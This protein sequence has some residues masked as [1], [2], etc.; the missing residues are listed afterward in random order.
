MKKHPLLVKTPKVI[1]LE[2]IENQVDYSDT[3]P[4][5][6]RIIEATRC[7]ETGA[8]IET[9]EMY[10]PRPIL[11]EQNTH[12]VFSRNTG[13]SRAIPLKTML[14]E[15]R[16]T[17]FIPMFWGK[18]NLVCSLQRPYLGLKRRC[19]QSLGVFTVCLPLLQ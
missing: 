3:L 19:V 17:P 18:I 6:A 10:F 9:F 16:R 8:T 12:R 11:A 7:I 15:L 2:S 5:Y 13:S 14:R 1:N 4:I